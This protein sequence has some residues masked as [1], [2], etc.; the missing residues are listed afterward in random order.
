MM[1]RLLL[2]LGKRGNDV[3][4]EDFAL[5]NSPSLFSLPSFIQS[6]R[7]YKVPTVGQEAC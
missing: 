3:S 5:R 4:I 2:L 6:F 7:E 1:D